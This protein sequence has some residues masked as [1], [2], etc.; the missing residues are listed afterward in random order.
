V[1]LDFSNPVATFNSVFLVHMLFA[2]L[3]QLVTGN[4]VNQLLLSFFLGC[5]IQTSLSTAAFFWVKSNLK[6]YFTLAEYQKCQLA[7]LQL[8]LA[9]R[10]IRRDNPLS[11]LL[12]G[13]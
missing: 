6:D 12:L 10:P 11:R 3:W 2:I 5:S 13:Q 1:A 8:S 7:C 4:S 9:R